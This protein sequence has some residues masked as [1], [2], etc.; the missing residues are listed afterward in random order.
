VTG[1][2]G[3]VARVSALAAIAL[4]IGLAVTPGAGA[5]SSEIP[6][7]AQVIAGADTIV[8]GRLVRVQPVDGAP[9]DVV[10]AV[11]RVLKGSSEPELHLVGPRTGLCGDGLDVPL[12]SRLILAT[13]VAFYDQVIT[14]FWTTLDGDLYG[15]AELPLGAATIDQVAATV[16]L[17]VDQLQ[18]APE[19]PGGPTIVALTPDVVISIAIALVAIV[20]G[21]LLVGLVGRR[22]RSGGSS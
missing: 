19:A 12:G 21:G 5:C 22:G 17:E 9:D 10:L 3:G 15:T 18:A 11:E 1:W 4:G 8:A 6:S 20:V 16:A 7:F 13:D 14:P 2:R